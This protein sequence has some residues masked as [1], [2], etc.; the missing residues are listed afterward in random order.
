MSK[1][2]P[3]VTYV[4][5]LLLVSV[6][7]GAPL[8]FADVYWP[9]PVRENNQ[10]F[11]IVLTLTPA[12]CTSYGNNDDC[13]NGGHKTKHHNYTFEHFHLAYSIPKTGFR[14][15]NPND[16]KDV[17]E[18]NIDARWYWYYNDYMGWSA[19]PSAISNQQNFNCWSYALNYT[20]IW[21][22]NPQP[23]GND[24]YNRAYVQYATLAMNENHARLVLDWAYQQP[25]G[26]PW[27]TQS[28]EKFCESKRYDVFFTYGNPED[29]QVYWKPKP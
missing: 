9:V 6:G 24:D 10:N 29:I 15:G 26:I 13:G 1:T 4:F 12:E 2:R 8:A 11:T 21:V 25:W 5:A 27:V 17:T 28:R 3:V 19:S 7:S 16:P 20:S 18:T 14:N 23:I 22:N